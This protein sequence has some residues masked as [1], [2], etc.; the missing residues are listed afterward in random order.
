MFDH[1][2][3]VIMGARVRQPADHTLSVKVP[4]QIAAR[5]RE[6]AHA[7]DR[8]VSGELRRIIRQW[9]ESAEASDGR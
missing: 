5:L 6:Y 7:H 8:T 4:T 9:A 1:R 2:E 3:A